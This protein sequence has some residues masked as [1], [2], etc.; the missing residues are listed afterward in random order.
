MKTGPPAAI[1]GP[2]WPATVAGGLLL[3]LAGAV[4][5]GWLLRIEW[6]VRVLPAAP[7]MRFNTAFLWLLSGAGLVALARQRLGIAR[8]LGVA[9]LFAALVTLLQYV[10]G[11]NLGIDNLLVQDWTADAY[12][13][14]GRMAP[15]TSLCF[16]LVGASLAS[17]AFPDRSR[18]RSLV[19]C[20]CGSA[21]AA[22][23]T[24]T[25]FGYLAGHDADYGWF[26][27]GGMAIHTALAFAVCGSVIVS[28]GL[29]RERPWAQGGPVWLPLPVL[30]G[31]CATSVVT[32]QALR[33][34]QQKSERRDAQTRA[35]HLAQRLTGRLQ[36]RVQALERMAQR[37]SIAGRPE[38]HVWQADAEMYL[39]HYPDFQ[40]I[41]WTTP[42]GRVKWLT[43]LRGNEL[44]QNLNVNAEASRRRSFAAARETR[45]PIISPVLDLVQGGKG[46]VVLC[47]IH[48]GGEFEG[49][50]SAAFR[51]PVLGADLAGQDIAGGYDV[52]LFDEREQLAGSRSTSGRRAGEALATLG[53]MRLRV[54]VTPTAA[55]TR[56]GILPEVVLGLGLLFA[57]LTAALTYFAQASRARQSVAEEATNALRS[58]EQKLRAIFDQTF[59]FIG[60][61][62][63]E[64]VV[65]AANRTALDFAGVEESDVIGRPFWDTAWWTHSPELQQALRGAVTQ[66][67]GGQL[68]RMESTHCDRLGELHVIDFSLKPVCDDS[69]QVILL[70]PEGRD[71]T[72]RKQAEEQLARAA[73]LDK[74]TGLPNRGLLLDRLQQTIARAQRSQELHYAVMFLDF[75]RF[76]LINDSLGHEAGD[77][78]LQQIACRLQENVRAVDS[79]SL[80]IGGNTTARLGGDE[81]VILLDELDNPCDVVIVAERLQAAFAQPYQIGTHEVHSTAS[82]GIVV[83]STQYERA[84]E[85]LRDADTAMYEA[86]RAGRACSCIFTASMRAQAQR[87]LQLEI[88][89]RKAA[90]AGQLSL[91]Y[92]PILSLS[93]G[94]ISGVEALLRWV[95]PTE[96]P[97]EPGEFLPIA[98]E[99]DL[100]FSLDDWVLLAACRQIQS[101]IERLGATAPAFI[102]VNLSPRQLN[103]PDLVA[104]LLRTLET[105]GLDPRRL[106]LEVSERSLS[107]NQQAG[108]ET[109]H[110]LRAAGIRLA[111]DDYGTGC[112]SFASVNR[113]PIEMLKVDGRLLAGVETSKDVAALVHSLAVLVKNLGISLVAEG[114]ETS[115]QTMA[116]QELGCDYAQGFFFAT[117]MPG[118]DLEQFLTN[119]AGI[120]R[121]TA[122]AM[123]F[124]HRW[125]GQL[126]LATP[127]PPYQGA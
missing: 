63:P 42:R 26:A 67:A 73:R 3:L 93:S 2:R 103:A 102:S 125:A 1:Q 99:S 101:W 123:A 45:Q 49:T 20:L 113:F 52:A 86:K 92:Q 35:A 6:L 9:V 39:R 72:D 18:R 23:G 96:G 87:R 31:L 24:V 64:G 109:L 75:D 55:S 94:E 51:L 34:E 59:Q 25:A 108:I 61:L 7:P 104:K 22:L 37:W 33:L 62:S 121:E 47:P 107:T 58:S 27:S 105:V 15:N 124:A 80:S 32:W 70:I 74:L 12:N 106:Q 100:I 29:P 82:I 120:D 85:V 19:V 16:V 95:H 8:V 68:V 126:T 40:V 60:L 116:L 66:A 53:G 36:D 111:I 127:L 117:P 5:A 28:A 118:S 69:G 54:R 11:T 4:I 71:I 84:E 76:K 115:R 81:F 98:D 38:Q 14:P 50:I 89:L 112:L 97:I 83:G 44:I 122:G 110:R 114:V 79:V 56:G 119:S 13:P 30:I 43:P 88:D 57:L 17:L 77:M 90:A 21:V 48:S 78:L 41:A 65:L 46:I 10:V 91:V